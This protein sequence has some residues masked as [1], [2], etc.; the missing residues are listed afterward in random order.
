M[1]ERY[2]VVVRIERG[3]STRVEP[4]VYDWEHLA[5]EAEWVLEYFDYLDHAERMIEEI[6]RLVAEGEV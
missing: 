6:G 3:E 1:A 4:G 5:T 2:R